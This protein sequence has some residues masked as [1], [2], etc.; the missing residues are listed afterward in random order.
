MSIGQLE[1]GGYL[2]PD[3]LNKMH[4][5]GRYQEYRPMQLPFDKQELGELADTYFPDNMEREVLTNGHQWVTISEDSTTTRATTKPLN[6]V[7]FQALIMKQDWPEEPLYVIHNHPKASTLVQKTP[8]MSIADYSNAIHEREVL[9][10]IPSGREMTRNSLGEEGDMR[11]WQEVYN[12]FGGGI[13]TNDDNKIRIWSEGAE[14]NYHGNSKLA[15]EYAYVDRF[16]ENY[17]IVQEKNLINIRWASADE[18][19]SNTDYIDPVND[20]YWDDK[21]N[22]WFDQI[23]TLQTRDP[24]IR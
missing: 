14:T 7:L 19:E 1:V 5:L 23:S 10:I 24:S 21:Y 2:S 22:Q 18:N 8:D 3:V 11:R 15:L 16:D 4:E 17:N 6:E 13:Y 20:P 12:V 9:S